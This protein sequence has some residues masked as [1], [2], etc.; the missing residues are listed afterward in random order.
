MLDLEGISAGY[1]TTTVLRDVH[2]TVPDSSVVALIGAN[3]AGKSTLLRVA[4]GALR[5]WSGR[6]LLDDADITTRPP[7]RFAIAGVCHVPEGHG[8]FPPLSVRDNLLLFSRKGEERAALERAVDAFPDLGDRLNQPAGTMSG[9]QQQ[10]LALARAYV[11]GARVI[12]LD[13]VSM[14]LA[15]II[16]D[17]IFAFLDRIRAEGVSLLVVEQ[18]VNKVL[19]IADY[20]YILGRGEVIFAGDTAELAGQDVFGH[21][22]GIE[23]TASTTP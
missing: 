23:A 19:A 22:L 5:P 8:V 14:G 1:G 10:M 20:V 12:L 4:S 18:Y 15:P 7:H 2:L 6:I 11:S 21:Y 17:E 13:E 3:G 9:G 16:V